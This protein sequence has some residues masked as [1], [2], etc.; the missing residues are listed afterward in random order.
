M[1]SAVLT[2][3]VVFIVLTITTPVLGDQT[4]TGE[5]YLLYDNWGGTWVDAEKSRYNSE[6]DNMCWAAAASNV[7]DWTGWGRVAGITDTDQTFAYFQDHWTD[8]GGLMGFGWQ[9]WF[10]GTNPSSGW[11]GWS[12][13]DVDGGGFHPS[14]NYNSYQHYSSNDASAMSTINSYLRS[15]YGTSIGI[16][17]PGGH[18]ITVWGLTHD[19]D[20]STAYNGL[21]I[22]DSD[23]H[24]YYSSPP[25][26]LRY[27]NVE[28]SDG[29][30][31]L[32]DYYNSNEWYIGVVSGL[33]SAPLESGDLDGDHDIDVDDIN[34]LA[35]TLRG[36]A[37]A[38]AGDSF[39]LNSDGQINSSDMDTLVLEILGTAYGDS[40]LDGL[41]NIADY[42]N[43][44]NHWGEMT[45][46]SDGDFSGDGQ[47]SIAD[48]VLLKNSFGADNTAT[49]YAPEPATS[50]L[51]AL[52]VP[53]V[54]KRRKSGV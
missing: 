51:I 8:Q 53:M 48:Y 17:G 39:D 22:T 23:D 40:N 5:S 32:Q 31:Y 46:W 24:K 30:W 3:L 42:V 27:Y 45:G 47:V 41:V 28:Y 18:A 38:N 35:A 20:D 11:S 9:W 29:K 12:Q 36:E 19:T 34:L 54:L 2:T 16:Y 1:R 14:V 37:T 6:D 50:V 7:L 26:R 52:L 49:A 10:T 15:G 33:G 44:K 4:P 43:L 21:Y 25:D 13:V